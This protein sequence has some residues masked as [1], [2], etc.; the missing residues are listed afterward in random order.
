[1]KRW[2]KLVRF[3]LITEAR[4]L[5]QV[6]WHGSVPTGAKLTIALAMGYVI[7]PLDLIPDL[8]PILGWADDLT[9]LTGLIYLAY[10]MIPADIMDEIRGRKKVH[11]TVQAD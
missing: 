6:M 8:L 1:M 5:W 7:M 2:Q 3:G 4:T 10:R 9:V 11:V